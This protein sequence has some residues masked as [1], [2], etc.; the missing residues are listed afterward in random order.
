MRGG[1]FAV[2]GDLQETQRYEEKTFT[3]DTGLRMLPLH[4]D[5][6]RADHK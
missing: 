5:G 2:S 1:T 3:G 4:S 6:A